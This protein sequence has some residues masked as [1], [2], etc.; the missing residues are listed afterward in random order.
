MGAGQDRDPVVPGRLHQARPVLDVTSGKN[1]GRDRALVD[2]TSC[3]SPPW[4]GPSAAC[5]SGSAADRGQLRGAGAPAGPAPLPRG[6]RSRSCRPPPSDSTRRTSVPASCRL[7]ASSTVESRITVRLYRPSRRRPGRFPA[8][9]VEPIGIV[10]FHGGIGHEGGE[11][12]PWNH[13]RPSVARFRVPRWNRPTRAVPRWS[14][15]P[16]SPVPRWKRCR[17]TFRGSGEFHRG[18]N[19]VALSSTVEPR[20]R[21]NEVPPWNRAPLAM[22]FS[23]S[24]VEP[25]PRGTT[26]I[27]TGFHGGTTGQADEFH[28]G[29]GLSGDTLA[30]GITSRGRMPQEKPSDNLGMEDNPGYFSLLWPICR[31]HRL[32][33]LPSIDEMERKTA[34]IQAVGNQVRVTVRVSRRVNAPATSGGG[35]G[36]RPVRERM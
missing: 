29:T 22:P 12:P 32:G 24:T 1:Q 6:S 36:A 16:A 30:P 3:T 5:R 7:P 26:R 9:P 4:R 34:M 19:C 25:V 23:S 10:G 11:V 15:A 21:P 2:G 33:W 35:E 14:R 17:S 20:A 18:T 31:R 8:P 13:S 27:I 28:R